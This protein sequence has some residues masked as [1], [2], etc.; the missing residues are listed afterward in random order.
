[1]IGLEFTDTD[2]WQVYWRASEFLNTAQDTGSGFGLRLED[3]TTRML[4]TLEFLADRWPVITYQDERYEVKITLWCQKGV[5]VQQMRITRQEALSKE[6]QLGLS[7]N[8]AIQD[9]DYLEQKSD[10][11]VTYQRAPHGFG[12][13]ALED[14]SDFQV[15]QE[16]VCVVIGLFKDGVAQELPL[17]DFNTRLQNGPGIMIP[18]K[19]EFEENKKSV[20]FTATFKLQLTTLEEHWRNFI[21]P[22]A[23]LNCDIRSSIMTD[24]FP[25]DLQL[26]WYLCRNLEHIMSV[27]SVPL[28]TPAGETTVLSKLGSHSN[29]RPKITLNTPENEKHTIFENQSPIGKTVPVALTCGDFGD[30]RVTVSGS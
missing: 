27:C 28:E 22:S 24:P 21:L 15:D 18:V 12:I 4:P 10:I 5:V 16:R 19:H 11:P 20:E 25:G 29:G 6:I 13:I 7:P 8:F 9:L 23:E 3:V 1:M 26:S 17:G 30:H 2:A 14:Q